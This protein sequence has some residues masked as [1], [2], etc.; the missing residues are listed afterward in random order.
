MPYSITP[1]LHLLCTNLTFTLQFAKIH[2]L[3]QALHYFHEV[4]RHFPL[5]PFLHDGCLHFLWLYL[6]LQLSG[7]KCRVFDFPRSC[8]NEVFPFPY[9]VQRLYEISYRN[10]LI[11]RNCFMYTKE[12]RFNAIF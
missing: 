7:F 2:L 8:I 9:D 4:L 1:T 10:Y 5:H 11:K 6:F 3:R 12:F